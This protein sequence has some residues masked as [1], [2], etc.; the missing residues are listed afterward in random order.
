MKKKFFLSLA[1]GM[2]LFS[3]VAFAELNGRQVEAEFKGYFGWPITALCTGSDVNL[4]TDPGTDSNVITMLQKGDEFHITDVVFR[5]IFAF[6]KTYFLKLGM[7]EGWLGFVLSIE[8]AN[9]TR[10]KYVKLNLLEME[11]KR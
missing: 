8:Y 5:P 11:K 1:L 10:N 2:S 6:I 4:R 7:L 9:Y 3:S